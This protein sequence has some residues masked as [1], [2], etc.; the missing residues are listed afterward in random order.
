MPRNVNTVLSEA[1]NV[2]ENC[3]DAP[4][5]SVSLGG[6][7]TSVATRLATVITALSVLPSAVARMT[8]GQDW[9]GH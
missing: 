4:I 5:A 1:R 8:T 7:M 3:W 9:S 6:V 2:A